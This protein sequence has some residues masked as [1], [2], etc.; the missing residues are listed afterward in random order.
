MLQRQA[1][2]WDILPLQKP[3]EGC[4]SGHRLNGELVCVRLCVWDFGRGE[5]V[6]S[7]RGLISLPCSHLLS[8]G[9]FLRV[10]PFKHPLTYL[11]A[12]HN[13]HTPSR[14]MLLCPVTVAMA[15]G[16]GL[17][18]GPLAHV[19]SQ[20]WRLLPIVIGEQGRRGWK[21]GEEGDGGSTSGD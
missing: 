8:S 20:A 4:F 6:Q 10:R 14:R 17:T 11:T 7:M 3:L 21:Q 2:H 15:P 9:C 19:P 1:K 16:F 13:T 18:P 12:T 5:Q